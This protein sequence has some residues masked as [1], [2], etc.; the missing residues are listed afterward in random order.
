MP[1]KRAINSLNFLNV[2]KLLNII[3]LVAALT[4][5]WSCSKDD[6]PEKP[7]DA[8][9]RLYYSYQDKINQL[10]SEEDTL[11]VNLGDSFSLKISVNEIDIN[12]KTLTLIGTSKFDYKETGDLEYQF[13]TEHAGTYTLGVFMTYNQESEALLSKFVVNVP[14]LC[15]RLLIYEELKFNINVGN[16]DIKE[17][18]QAELEENYTLEFAGLYSLTCN[19]LTGGDLQL[20][21]AKKDT[22]SGIFSSSGIE[23][24]TDITMNYNN[25]TY[26]LTLEK[27][28]TGPDYYV[29]HQNLTE[30]FQKKYPDEP[31]NEV[32]ISSPALIHKTK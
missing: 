2:N 3:S 14:Y 17:A 30:E 21:T 18:I 15:Y 12:N 31:I 7:E 27:S 6:E 8:N 5:S 10:L 28:D 22:I 23:E 24:L 19:T 32:T 16:E 20:V 26:M 25:F 11:T 4:L 29:L 9:L 13:I 1:Y